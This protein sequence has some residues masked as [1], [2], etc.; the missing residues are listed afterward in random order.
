[1]IN[2]KPVDNDFILVV[3]KQEVTVKKG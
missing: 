1:M 2:E 3:G